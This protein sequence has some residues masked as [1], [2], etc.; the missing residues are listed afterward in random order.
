MTVIEKIREPIVS[1][2]RFPTIGRY[3]IPFPA[4][5]Y[6]RDESGK[7]VTLEKY[8]EHY[9]ENG[10]YNY[11]YNN[12][13]LEAKPMAK[14]VD[15]KTYNWFTD[16]LKQYLLVNPIA[17]FT[18]LEIG[19]KF[20]LQGKIQ[21]RK[22]DLGIVLNSNPVSLHDEDRS[23]KGVYDMCIEFVSDSTRA[24]IERDTKIKFREF[25]HVQIDELF[26]LS[27][28]ENI[29]KFYGL[30]KYGN[31]DEIKPD[32]NGVIH[33]KV[34][35][36]FR[37]RV[38]DIFDRPSLIDMA[39]DPVYQGFV[40]LEY[41]AERQRAEAERQRAEAAR[42]RAEAAR[43]RAEAARRR[44]K[45]ERQRAEQEQLAKEKAYAKLRELGIDPETL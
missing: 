13:I 29:L 19:F 22:P 30:N 43:Q 28:D 10:N 45:A 17:K 44:A 34:L 42:Q 21:V 2:P 5:Q 40:L 27:D 23:Y 35:P 15:V 16:T 32:K 41:Q 12:G 25:E 3:H 8:L 38:S 24:A 1:L 4:R 37:F 33:S 31:Y 36:G 7:R 6:S 26:L 11:E 39:N 14:Y 20:R 9:Y 18:T